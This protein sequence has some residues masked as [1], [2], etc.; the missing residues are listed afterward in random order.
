[1]G[2]ANPNSAKLKIG[3]Y[4]AEKCRDGVME[5]SSD[6]LS[7]IGEISDSYKVPDIIRSAYPGL[8]KFHRGMV[9]FIATDWN[10]RAEAL[11]N[12]ES[13]VQS[14]E[15]YSRHENKPAESLRERLLYQVTMAR[16]K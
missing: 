1:M 7:E 15:V 2:Y 6:E 8:F 5:F 12:L 13:Q 10:V 9:N 3:R 11:E 14:L 4:L 16:R